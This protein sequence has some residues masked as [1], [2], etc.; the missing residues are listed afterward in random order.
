[1][2]DNDA[3]SVERRRPEVTHPYAVRGP[4]WRLIGTYVKPEEAREVAARFEA[5]TGRAHV[6]RYE[7]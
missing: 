3:G 1:M 5:E 7:P 6:V 2:S 4:T